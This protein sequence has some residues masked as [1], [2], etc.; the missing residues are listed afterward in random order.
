MSIKFGK[1]L[2]ELRTKNDMSQK[3]LADEMN[4]ERTKVVRW[5]TGKY[6]PNLNELEK[7]A[8]LFNVTA[9]YLLG[10]ILTPFS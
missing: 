2:K 3:E 7:I 1:I 4:I 10:R 5:E 9:D 8:D 6:E